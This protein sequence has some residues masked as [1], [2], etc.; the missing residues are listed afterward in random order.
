MLS[1]DTRAT[2]RYLDV[3][4]YDLNASPGMVVDTPNLP[5]VYGRVRM[6]PLSRHVQ[7]SSCL[8]QP[9]PPPS[10]R[11]IFDMLRTRRALSGGPLKS[12]DALFFAQYGVIFRC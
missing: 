12:Y 5:D 6:L 10:F 2:G 11:E 3:A 8:K 1:P 9:F 7:L 4:R